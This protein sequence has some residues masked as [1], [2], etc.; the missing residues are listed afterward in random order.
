MAPAGELVTESLDYDGGRA[1]TAYVPS[2]PVDAAVF[3]ADGGWHISRLVDAMEKVDTPST[4]IVGVHGMADDEG[5]FREYV[6]GVE[7]ERFGAHEAFFLDVVGRWV[8]SRFGVA[9]PVDR[10]AVWGASLGGEFALALGFSHPEVFGAIFCASPG[11][12]YRPPGSLTGDV[13]AT[14]LVAGNQEMFFVENAR[15]WGDALSGAN[16][17]VSMNVREGG[18]GGEFW[19]T[20]F[21]LMVNWAFGG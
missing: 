7:P 14:Y 4:M 6:P 12:G 2:E 8:G 5:R 9:L 13:P 1:V 11:G 15:R 20:E 21:P 10:T 19:F 16:A 18:H 3:A 17:R